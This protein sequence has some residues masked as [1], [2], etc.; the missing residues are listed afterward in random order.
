MPTI[1]EID[2]IEGEDVFLIARPES[3]SGVVLTRTEVSAATLN[4]YER[5]TSTAVY[6]KTL[7]LA[8]DPPGAGYDECM[9]AALQTDGWWDLTGGYTF[10]AV[11]QLA[12]YAL[13]GGT[14]YRIEVKLTTGHSATAWPNLDDYGD[15]LY[16]WNTTP[17]AVST[18]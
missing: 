4:V 17:Q 16:I 11:I 5:G 14:S 18:V 12:G 3:P 10:W 13:K 15:Q 2:T 1:I 6:T 7:L 8:N 9:F